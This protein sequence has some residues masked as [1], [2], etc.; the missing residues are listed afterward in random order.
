VSSPLIPPA[1][2]DLNGNALG[3]DI[4]DIE[5]VKRLGC[6]LKSLD[7]PEPRLQLVP[8]RENA[9][10]HIAPISFGR[11]ATSSIF[12]A[13]GSRPKRS[14][15]PVVSLLRA[16]LNRPPATPAMY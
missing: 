4:T 6:A 9:G 13:D 1:A 11:F 16:N 8:I 7:L 2:A 10:H 12:A 5:I 3:P 14:T 15:D